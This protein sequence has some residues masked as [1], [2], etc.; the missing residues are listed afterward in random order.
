[1]KILWVSNSRKAPTGYGNQT[2]LFVPR[3]KAAGHE[4]DIF[5]Y[6]G[7][8]A[9]PVMDSDGILTLPLLHDVWGND[10]V[11]AHAEFRKSDAVITLCD[12]F[13]L[14]PG[15]YGKLEWC[16]WTP[17]DSAPALPENVEVLKSARWIWAMSRFGEE[18]LKNAG[19]TN[20]VYVPHGVD[21]DLFRP[22]DRGAARERIAK[23]L[24]ADLDGK[25]LIAMNSANKGTP[26]RKGFSEALEAFKQFSE[27]A[28][29]AVLY[30]H[31][32]YRGYW[33][34]EHLPTTIEALGI[35]PSKVLFPNQY[36]Y[37]MAL[38]PGEY[39]NDVY[40]AADVFLTTSHGEGFGIPIVEAQA[41]GCPVVVT[42]FSA[43]TE[44]KFSGFGVNSRKFMIRPG[45][46]HAIP[47]VDDVVDALKAI[48]QVDL[49]GRGPQMRESARA[50]A[51]DYDYRRVFE[52]YMRPAVEQ[53]G[54]DIAERKQREIARAEKRQVV[55][56]A[57]A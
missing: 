45:A 8:E 2:N 57:S 4:P 53:M 11:Q 9:V 21:T 48:R 16:A 56:N 43:M 52:K 32:D 54:A 33:H 38:L 1:M 34:G 50:G 3:L 41:S 19:F 55:R 44:L 30:I 46:Y 22:V 28:P 27:Q 37:D 51:L 47:D 17:I 40:N 14:N 42:A 49:L 15:V 24:R 13:V 31:T 6:Y 5:A 39:L 26:S 29:E 20:V 25:F 23:T 18:Q 10:V 7:A 35:D 36:L 12:P